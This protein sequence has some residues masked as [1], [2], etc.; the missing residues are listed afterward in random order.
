LDPVRGVLFS[1]SDPVDPYYESGSG[2]LIFNIDLKIFEK[3]M[4]VQRPLTGTFLTIYIYI[5]K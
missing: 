3:K 5:E 1:V 2:S 4:D